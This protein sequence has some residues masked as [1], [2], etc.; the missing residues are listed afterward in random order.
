MGS[1]GGAASR[2][3]DYEKPHWVILFDELRCLFMANYQLD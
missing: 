2:D 3:Q 1:S